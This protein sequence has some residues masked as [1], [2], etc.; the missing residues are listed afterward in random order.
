MAYRK[1]LTKGGDP[2][3]RGRAKPAG[4]KTFTEAA[5]A[6]YA[7]HETT[8]TGAQ[9]ATALIVRLRVDQV[10]DWAK[11]NG[12]RTGDNPIDALAPGKGF[13]AQVRAVRRHPA[14]PQAEVCQFVLGPREGQSSAAKLAFEFL[15]L[16]ACRTNEVLGARWD[17]IDAIKRT[18][19]VPSARMKGERRKAIRD[20]TSFCS[21]TARSKFCQRQWDLMGRNIFSHR[22]GSCVAKGS[23]RLPKQTDFSERLR[24]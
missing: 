9:S 3:V 1:S 8:L 10:L 23:G 15:I 19:L 22:R 2:A 14:L 5:I 16:T 12:Y 4:R 6:F 17:E 18:W 20:P 21:A 11:L 24:F 7:E 13:P